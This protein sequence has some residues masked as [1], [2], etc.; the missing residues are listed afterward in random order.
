M[1]PNCNEDEKGNFKIFLSLY[2]KIKTD[3]KDL[4]QWTKIKTLKTKYDIL[5]NH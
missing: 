4:P 5:K 2:S 3:D 1:D